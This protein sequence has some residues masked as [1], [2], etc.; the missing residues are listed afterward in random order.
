[1][2]NQQTQGQT[3]QRSKMAPL[4]TFGKYKGVRISQVPMSYLRWMLSQKF[5]PDL[6][7]YAKEKLV[8]NNTT[9]IDLD[10]TRHA[11][12]SFSVRYL[13]IWQNSNMGRLGKIIGIGTFLA[14]IANKA[15]IEG[16]DVSKNRHKYEEIIKEYQGIKFVFNRDGISRVL[17][18]II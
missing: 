10:I 11:Y 18:T 16:K 14:E 12:D 5:S 6:L 3:I 8:T 2:K 7:E 9:N 15:F 13:G 1:M 17:I 4:L